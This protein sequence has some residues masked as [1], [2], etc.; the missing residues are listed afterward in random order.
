MTSERRQ[1]GR[2]ISGWGRNTLSSNRR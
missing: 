2:E 1:A